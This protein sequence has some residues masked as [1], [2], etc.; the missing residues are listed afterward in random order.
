MRVVVQR[1]EGSAVAEVIF[2]RPEKR[3]AL[4]GAM[5]EEILETLEKLR[6]D[7]EIKVLITSGA[8]EKAY[9]AGMDLHYLRQASSSSR[10]WSDVPLLLQAVAM[11][12]SLPQVTISKVRGYCLGAGLTLVAAHELAVAAE[13]SWFG[14]PEVMRGDFGRF[15][16]ASLFHSGLS[17]KKAFLMQLTGD[18]INGIEAERLGLVSHVVADDELDEFTSELATRISTYERST[19]EH[20]KIAAYLAQD[21]N[22]N[23]AFK[24]DAL[25]AARLYLHLNPLE[26]VE[27][28]LASRKK[29]KD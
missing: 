26:D 27:D 9:S 19:L 4:D 16:T 12:R 15:T 5:L 18:Q 25:V 10:P 2:N 1:A 14:A 21:R 23:E 3:N 8:G 11:L 28:F 29:R 17:F 7:T 22:L 6:T 13:S 20:A 24:T